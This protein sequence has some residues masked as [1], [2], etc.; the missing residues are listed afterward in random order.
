LDVPVALTI[1]GPFSVTDHQLG[2]YQRCPR[3]FLYTHVIEVGGR[4][5]ENAFMRLHVAVQ[6]VVE[7]VATRTRGGVTHAELDSM[8][9]DAWDAH[10]PA[11]DGYATEYKQIASGLLR[12]FADTVAGRDL[13]PTPK[14]RLPIAGGEIV[15]TPDHVVRDTDGNIAMRRVKTGH[16]VENDDDGLAAAA[17]YLA[18]TA[19]TPG[20]TVEFVYLGD[21]EASP[22]TM[23]ATVLRNRRASI[24]QMAEAVRT[25]VFPL[26]ETPTCPRCPAFFICGCLPAGP[27]A[28][29]F[30]S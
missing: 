3:R 25:G 30:S 14:L 2:L 22:V 16:R 19:H 4:R 5:T 13:H 7:A 21:G 17:F 29:K 24:D 26:K 27:L 8:L 15:I 12:Y 11:D 18:A 9:G 6:K 1:D 28:K 20:C 23:S 10:G